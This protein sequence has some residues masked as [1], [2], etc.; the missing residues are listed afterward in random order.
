MRL[1]GIF[2]FRLLCLL[3]LS[4]VAHP[5]PAQQK[6]TLDPSIMKDPTGYKLRSGD[7]IRIMVNGEPDATVDASLGNYGGVRP[8]YLDEVKL[9]GLN[10]DQASAEIAKQYQRQLIYRRPSVSILI[11]KYTQQMVFLSGSV[12][13]KGPYSFPPEVE[14]MNIVEVIARAGGFND[15]A[16]KNKVYVTRTFFNESG[17]AKETKTYEVDVEAL[18]TGSI[19]GSNQRFWIYPG[20]RIE[21]PER[22]I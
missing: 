17:S 20:D 8:A 22:L 11:T 10:V 9:V 15:I 3:V 6:Y 16:K 2:V 19:R 13:K 1:K 18:S 12:N 7:K 4:L 5:L 21:V 14:A